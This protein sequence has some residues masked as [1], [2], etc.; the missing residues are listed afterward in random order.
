MAKKVS[1]DALAKSLNRLEDMA[2]SQ[3]FH[4]AKDSDP[5]RWAGSNFSDEDSMD[6]NLEDNGLDY[7]GVRAALGEAVAKGYDPTDAEFA[8]IKGEDPTGFIADKIEKGM[9]LTPAEQWVVDVVKSAEGDKDDVPRKPDAPGKD[10]DDDDAPE[11]HAGLDE[12]EDEKEV[13]KSFDSAVGGSDVMRKGIEM[14]PFLY[15]FANAIN[16]ALVGIEARLNKS[17]EAMAEVIDARDAAQADFFKS[18]AESVVG[19][20]EITKSLGEAN[21]AVARMPARAP[22]SVQAPMAKSIGG[23]VVDSDSMAKSQVLSVMEDMVKSNKLA[24]TEV[25]KYETSGVMSPQAQQL[26]TEWLNSKR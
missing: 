22:K 18:L 6:D 10:V 23:L 13:H 5:K 4:T 3:L 14:S 26:V 2:K 8:L 1:T 25:I 19:I 12:E 21:T 16:T 11:S 7:N 20:G 9:D 24:P 15:E 17:L